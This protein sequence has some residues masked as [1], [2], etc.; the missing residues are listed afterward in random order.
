MIRDRLGNSSIESAIKDI[1]EIVEGTNE[2]L[3]PDL[4]EN[5]KNFASY[6]GAFI[7]S[8][9]AGEAI[10]FS[11]HSTEGAEIPYRELVRQRISQVFE[12][13]SDEVFEI[14]FLSQFSK[15]LQKI[16]E[17]HPFEVLSF[18]KEK[19][20]SN[21]TDVEMVSEL[22]WWVS[23]QESP[24]VKSLVVEILATG[25]SHSSALVRDTAA[26]GIAD[27]DEEVAIKHIQ[28]AIIREKVPELRADMQDL[29][30][31]LGNNAHK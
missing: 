19:L 3:N 22:L 16:Y 28:Q 12:S 13:A 26:N 8:T 14:G 5:R 27:V 11:N 17:Q 20:V 9:F 4:D 18:A 23:R 31:T 25:L 10:E 7:N 21:Q 30:R 6:F 15:N 24:W 1:T 2:T 29:V